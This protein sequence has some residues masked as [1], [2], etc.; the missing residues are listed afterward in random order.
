MISSNRIENRGPGAR[1]IKL[2][3]RLDANA[4]LARRFLSAHTPATSRPPKQA[5][6]R[7]A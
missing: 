6:G 5:D 4:S 3:K 7:P 1:K 2:E